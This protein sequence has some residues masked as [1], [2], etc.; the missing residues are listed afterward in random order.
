MVVFTGVDETL[1]ALNVDPDGS[2][3]VTLHVD[4]HGI[5]DHSGSGILLQQN[6]DSFDVLE[7]ILS[8]YLKASSP[9]TNGSPTTAKYRWNCF[10]LKDF[11]EIRHLVLFKEGKTLEVFRDAVATVTDAQAAVK[12]IRLFLGQPASMSRFYV[13]AVYIAHDTLFLLPMSLILTRTRTLQ[14]SLYPAPLPISLDF[15]K[16]LLRHYHGGAEMI[17]WTVKSSIFYQSIPAKVHGSSILDN[18][19]PVS[20]LPLSAGAHSHTN[21]NVCSLLCVFLISPAASFSTPR[22]P[23]CLYCRSHASILSDM[24]CP[25]ACRRL[26]DSQR[27]VRDLDVVYA[28]ATRVAYGAQIEPNRAAYLV[29]H[30]IQGEEADGGE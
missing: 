6:Y 9:T 4:L 30:W 8:C 24:C 18:A 27:L 12:A 25:A 11:A 21:F 17:K 23:F 20:S 2:G 1:L 7:S 10:S 22:H 19:L 13:V 29:A 28:G 5:S 26:P 14:P 16:A 15:D 3:N